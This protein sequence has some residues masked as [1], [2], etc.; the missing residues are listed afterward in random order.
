MPNKEKFKPNAE[1]PS[2]IPNEASAS[3]G[4]DPVEELEKI[5]KLPRGEKKAAVEAYKENLLQQREELTGIETNLI[6]VFLEN[7][8]LD[9]ASLHEL[10]EKD[11]A[12][13]HL[14]HTQKEIINDVIP[15]VVE[16]RKFIRDLRAQFPDDRDLFF[17]LFGFQPKK[18]IKISL[19]ALSLE[20]EINDIKDSAAI[21]Q[22]AF[23]EKRKPTREEI[24]YA[25]Y[26]GAKALATTL[27]DGPDRLVIV[28]NHSAEARKAMEEADDKSFSNESIV[29]HEEQHILNNFFNATRLK[30]YLGEKNLGSA[31]E[32]LEPKKE[33]ELYM[34]LFRKYSAEWDYKNEALAYYKMGA[35]LDLI[36][37]EVFDPKGG[38]YPV[39]V[40]KRSF[41]KF[42]GK[43]AN[44]KAWKPFVKEE[45]KEI[46]E[47]ELKNIESNA[48]E[49]MRMLESTG[50]SRAEI[51]LLLANEPFSGW[52]KF[53]ARYLEGASKKSTK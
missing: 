49:A 22:G 50:K 41:S 14:S 4:F 43:E 5:K 11:A 26:V 44:R 31:T 12:H 7:P 9:E 6:Q 51:I 38:G 18:D 39:W 10:F 16:R 27:V 33:L 47:A 32:L 21:T 36:A 15:E 24:E 3:S 30:K 25:Q 23:L 20:V 34:H 35:P 37:K 2:E 42:I 1:A 17:H 13:G 40:Y 19:A 45:F 52:K 28:I 8:D 29:A 48:I 53:A 46:F